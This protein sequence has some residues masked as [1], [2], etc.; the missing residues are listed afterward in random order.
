MSFMRFFGV[1]AIPGRSTNRASRR[2][3]GIDR[4]FMYNVHDGMD[5]SERTIAEQLKSAG[6]QTGMVGKWRL[7]HLDRYIPWNQGIYEFYGVTFSNDMS[8]L[9]FYQ[10]QKIIHKP[11]DQRYLA[12]HLVINALLIAAWRRNPRNELLVHID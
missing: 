7:G 8:N 4:V 3:L 1:F 9:F 6:Y 2:T 12:R 5:A 10:N 11:I